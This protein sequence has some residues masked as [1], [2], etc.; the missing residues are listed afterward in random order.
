MKIHKNQG[1][2]SIISTSIHRVKV[3][4][5]SKIP[6]INGFQTSLSVI[7]FAYSD[8]NTPTLKLAEIHFPEAIHSL[9]YMLYTL[10]FP[11]FHFLVMFVVTY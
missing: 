8:P 7:L 2:D 4:K 11:L 10:T 5:I 9:Y 6:Q 3:D 1:K